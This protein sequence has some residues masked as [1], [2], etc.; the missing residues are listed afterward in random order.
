MKVNKMKWEDI[1][2]SGELSSYVHPVF[3][4]IDADTSGVIC[5][6]CNSKDVVY[7]GFKNDTHSYRAFLVCLD[8]DEAIEF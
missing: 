1:I 7:R 4:P 8:C 2:Q 6:E 3:N 5:P